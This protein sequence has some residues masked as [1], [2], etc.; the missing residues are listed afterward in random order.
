MPTIAE[1]ELTPKPDRPQPI[2]S[3]AQLLTIAARNP[4]I[5]HVLTA[6]APMGPVE[7]NFG[8]RPFKPGQ[9]R[10]PWRSADLLGLP[11]QAADRRNHFEP[12]LRPW[13]GFDSASERLL[14]LNKLEEAGESR[15]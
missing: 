12:L 8:C 5:V 14:T 2:T 15:P 4:H 11:Q 7:K 13:P 3:P 1:Q 9:V 10:S 6:F